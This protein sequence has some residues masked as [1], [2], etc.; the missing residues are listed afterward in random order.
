MYDW[1][2]FGSDPLC[3]VYW[4]CGTYPEADGDVDRYG[5]PIEWLTGESKPYVALVE[6]DF[7]PA[8]GGCFDVAPVNEYACG[9]WDESY[10]ITHYM[11]FEPP[12]AHGINSEA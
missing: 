10:G 4:V 1:K 11:A 5:Q 7:D 12:A 3:G 2:P 9:R 8:P 6:I